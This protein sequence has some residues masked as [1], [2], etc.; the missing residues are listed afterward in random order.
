MLKQPPFNMKASIVT[1]LS[2]K[3]VNSKMKLLTQNFYY[4][5]PQYFLSDGNVGQNK[6]DQ[7]IKSFRYSLFWYKCF[8]EHQTKTMVDFRLKSK[9][10][11]SP[12]SFKAFF[13]S[14]I[15]IS[16]FLSHNYFP[17]CTN[18]LYSTYEYELYENGAFLLTILK[19]FES[20]STS[21]YTFILC[22]TQKSSLYE[23]SVFLGKL[24]KL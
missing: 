16:I 10:V 13:P 14:D 15:K 18:K 2:K 1:F 9:S 19:Q 8:F 20:T 17:R 4:L 24:L 22:T 23:N 5:A 7:K 21:L 11:W 6:W 12:G 3:L